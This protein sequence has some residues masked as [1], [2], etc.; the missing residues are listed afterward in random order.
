MAG[1]IPPTDVLAEQNSCKNLGYYQYHFN[2]EAGSLACGQNYDQCMDAYRA[3]SDAYN[4]CIGADGGCWDIGREAWLEGPGN[5]P[6]TDDLEA[7]FKERAGGQAFSAGNVYYC[8]CVKQCEDK[9]PL[10][11]D[12]DKCGA[13]LGQCC[14]QLEETEAADAEDAAKTTDK[15]EDKP[16]AVLQ[17]TPA[18]FK[19]AADGTARQE[20]TAELTGSGL[21][22]KTVTMRAELSRPNRIRAGLVTDVSTTGNTLTATYQSPKF[23]AAEI[24]DSRDELVDLIYI[25]ATVDGAEQYSTLKAV[26]LPMDEREATITFSKPGLSDQIVTSQFKKG[27]ISGGI[28][29]EDPDSGEKMPL[30][31]VEVTLRVPAG[32]PEQQPVETSKIFDETYFWERLTR[33]GEEKIDVIMQPDEAGR[34]YMAKAASYHDRAEKFGDFDALNYHRQYLRK[35]AEAEQQEA[36]KIADAMKLSAYSLFFLVEY[37]AKARESLENTNEFFRAALNDTASLVMSFFSLTDATYAIGTR[38][39]SESPLGKSILMFGGKNSADGTKMRFARSVVRALVHGVRDYVKNNPNRAYYAKVFLGALEGESI[40]QMLAFKDE[41]SLSKYLFGLIDQHLHGYYTENVSAMMQYYKIDPAKVSA[42][43]D[44]NIELAAAVFKANAEVHDLRNSR[45][46]NWSMG[47]A[48]GNL[49]HDIGKATAQLGTTLVYGPQAAA[50]LSEVLDKITLAYNT[51]K[52]GISANA[53]YE[54]MILY[55]DDEIDLNRSMGLLFEG[56]ERFAT[57]KVAMATPLSAPIGQLHFL[58]AAKALVPKLSVSSQLITLAETLA[59]GDAEQ[60]ENALQL[61]LDAERSA[62][63]EEAAQRA[64]YLAT[65]G[66]ISEIDGETL[67]LLEKQDEMDFQRSL[68]DL[69]LMAVEMD[70]SAETLANFKEKAGALT[71]LENDYAGAASAYNDLTA[72]LRASQTATDDELQIAE[73]PSTSTASSEANPAPATTS[74]MLLLLV[75][76][77]ALMLLVA[78]ILLIKKQQLAGVILLIIAL[79]GGSAIIYLLFAPHADQPATGKVGEDSK[80]QEQRNSFVDLWDRPELI[81][82]S[83]KQPAT[84]SNEP[85]ANMDNAENMETSKTSNDALSA[86]QTMEPATGDSASRLQTIMSAAHHFSLNYPAELTLLPMVEEE[87]YLYYEGD[88]LQ[89]SLEAAEA[90]Q[91]EELIGENYSLPDYV[92]HIEYFMFAERS[93]YEEMSRDGVEMVRVDYD[94]DPATIV[95]YWQA[96]LKNLRLALTGKLVSQAD[97]V[98]E[99]ILDSLQ[100]LPLSSDGIEAGS[101]ECS[102]PN[103]DVEYWWNEVSQAERDCFVQKYGFTPKL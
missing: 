58:P 40:N 27:A 86:G 13:G 53:S 63:E 55:W 69:Q 73:K 30:K 1:L 8:Q 12:Y 102:H 90:A 59:G 85:T 47:V 41:N 20:I 92:E 88:D 26:L 65:L 62:E 37:D 17:L 72:K 103:G 50:A 82:P 76:I 34:K 11:A 39:V 51:L 18:E 96:G 67:A 35:L 43:L 100:L 71:E 28:F 95:L 33:T 80:W 48:W 66:T 83:E 32:T 61:L 24:T 77:S 5:C 23:S 42:D 78:L 31:G 84:E 4:K 2:N 99:E 6:Q 79:L 68:L 52:V 14:K 15:T 98:V 54:W 16:Q 19:I 91:Y 101:A 46:Y 25:Y 97:P 7:F 94:R 87:D 74:N 60:S 29:L 93:K 56:K 57:P 45:Q 9:K 64:D 75:V 49:I 44:R 81:T 36:K 10:Q 70:P 38:D 3:Q 89:I 21:A 22:G